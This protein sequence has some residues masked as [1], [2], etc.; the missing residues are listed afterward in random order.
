MGGLSVVE[1]VKDL[2]WQEETARQFA[3][4]CLE[5]Y[6]SIDWKAAETGLRCNRYAVPAGRFFENAHV[7]FAGV[8][9]KKYIPPI[10]GVGG[11]GMPRG[12][13]RSATLLLCPRVQPYPPAQCSL[14]QA[15]I[16]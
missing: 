10:S 12:N 3:Q 9:L 11:G 8:S 2:G 14:Q 7:L 16:T 6:E 5:A 1:R 4:R 13:G 15:E